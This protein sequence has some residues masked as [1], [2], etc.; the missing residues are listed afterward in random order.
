MVDCRLLSVPIFVVTNFSIEQ[1]LIIPTTMEDM[2]Y[3]PYA[4]ANGNVVYVIVFT[5]LD[6]SQTMGVLIQFMVNPGCEHWVVV[7]R[8]FRYLQGTFE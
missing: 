5:R 7:K 3:V 4:S 6:T 1:C 8:I 2:D